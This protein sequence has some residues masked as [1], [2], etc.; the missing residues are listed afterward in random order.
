V[1]RRVDRV[2]QPD[3][4]MTFTTGIISDTHGLLRPGALRLLAQVDHVIHA[5][6]DAIDAII[7]LRPRSELEPPFHS[8]FQ[9]VT[10]I[11]SRRT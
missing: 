3:A 8:T 11:R 5:Y 9:G 1:A 7:S 2:P 6:R 4:A 10:E